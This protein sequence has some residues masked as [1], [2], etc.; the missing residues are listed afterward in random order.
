MLESF[1]KII[2]QN[3]AVSLIGALSVVSIVSSIILVLV[4]N[5]S[6]PK[7]QANVDASIKEAINNIFVE[8]KSIEKF[9]QDNLFKVFDT[10]KKFVGYAFLSKGN[11][12]Q[13]VI[14]LIIG[15]DSSIQKV[16]GIDVIESQ[17]TPGLGANIAEDFFK[18]Q[19]I[20]LQVDPYVKYLK[21]E[22]KQNNNEIEAIT[23]ATISSRAVVGIINKNV[24][25][26]RSILKD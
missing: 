17:E 23:G 5:Y 24:K 10:N 20:G 16:K 11:G 1:K 6:I 25:D 26:I 8:A 3:E 15:F 7:I 13:G 19:F 4:Y 18:S 14:R 9:K 21:N 22:K 2:K 12:Y